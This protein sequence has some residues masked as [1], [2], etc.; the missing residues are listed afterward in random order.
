MTESQRIEAMIACAEAAHEANRAYCETLGN[1]SQVPFAD[2]PA[3]Q[4]L[5]AL[6]GVA[7]VLDGNGPERTHESWLGEKERGGWVYGPV[8]DPSKK[9][10]PCMVPYSELAPEQRQKDT[11]FVATVKAAAWGWG[12]LP[13]L[14][15]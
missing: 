9:E 11:L 6:R 10:H 12:L 15:E 4:V 3:W 14:A 1:H 2:A 13:D 5:S 8:K 7:G